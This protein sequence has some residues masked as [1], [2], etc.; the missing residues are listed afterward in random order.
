MDEEYSLFRV[1]VG[2]VWPGR[3]GIIFGR[4]VPQKT[5]EVA[6][7]FARVY[8]FRFLRGYYPASSVLHSRSAWNNKTRSW[9]KPFSALSLVPSDTRLQS[10]TLDGLQE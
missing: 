4:V 9:M 10:Y 7:T 2:R 3:P 8:A 6:P 5:L 1:R